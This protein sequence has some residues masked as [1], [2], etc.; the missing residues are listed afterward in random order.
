MASA[1]RVSKKRKF[2]ADGVMFAEINE[3]LGK[4][5]RASFVSPLRAALPPRRAPPPPARHSPRRPP[6]PTGA[7]RRGLWRH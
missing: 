1:T 5:R 2:V 6:V 3:L 4:V 7:H